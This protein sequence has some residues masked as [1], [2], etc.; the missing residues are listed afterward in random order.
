MT[1]YLPESLES[2]RIHIP[3]VIY[4]MTLYKERTPSKPN[5]LGPRYQYKFYA[6]DVDLVQ[7]GKP[8]PKA[9]ESGSKRRLSRTVEQDR[10]DRY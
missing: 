3:D 10:D 5:H 2:F 7:G 8:K 9:S 1:S 4:D 6:I